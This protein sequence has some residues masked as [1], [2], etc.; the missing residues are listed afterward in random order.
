MFCF[1]TVFTLSHYW[2]AH[3]VV[4]AQV[5][6]LIR[7]QQTKPIQKNRHVQSQILNAMSKYNPKLAEAKEIVMSGD[8]T[9]TEKS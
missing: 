6:Y 2:D 9:K 1:L 3:E 4:Q 7:R 8:K 5:F